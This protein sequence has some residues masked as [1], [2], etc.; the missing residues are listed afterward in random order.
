MAAYAAHYRALELGPV[1]V[2][3]PNGAGYAVVGVLL[4]VVFLGER[5]SAVAIVGM[6][7]AVIG[8][9]LV[10]TDLR[11]LRAGL[12]RRPPG[13]PLAIVSA[14]LFGLGGFLL[15]YLVQRSGDWVA[16][17]WA[18][19]LSLLIVFLPFI[20]SHRSAFA[21]ARSAGLLAVGFA[22]A[23]G[24][25]DFVGVTSYSAGAEAGYIS[26][27]IAASA[28]FPVV[29]VALSVK[30]LHE[31]LVVNQAVGIALVVAGLLM[32]GLGTF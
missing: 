3:Y 11:A 17:L 27:V 9:M 24:L 6:V 12:A 8:T 30:L 25:A 31:R 20:A 5:P 16:A 26:I 32:L 15:G 28:V 14:V 23:T 19:R 18:S 4:A 2:V 1:A 7:V 22:L 29:A 10:S 21:A 13:L